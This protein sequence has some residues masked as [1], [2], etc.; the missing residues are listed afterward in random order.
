MGTQEKLQEHF[1]SKKC[2]SAENESW[3]PTPYLC[4]LQNL[5]AYTYTLPNITP[6][7]WYITENVRLLSEK[8]KAVGTLSE[9]NAKILKLRQPIKIEFDYAAKHPRSLG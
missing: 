1:F 4:T 9:S 6:Y 2:Q 7:I 3:N 5:T 8:W